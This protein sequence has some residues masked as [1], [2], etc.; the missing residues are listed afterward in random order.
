VNTKKRV[1]FLLLN[2]VGHAAI[3]EVED[4]GQRFFFVKI[5]AVE[6][7]RDKA[8][9]GRLLA[10]EKTNVSQVWEARRRP[11]A[12]HCHCGAPLDDTACECEACAADWQEFLSEARDVRADLYS[13]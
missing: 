3:A 13:F 6:H 11:A 4:E 8:K 2:R 5:T 1:S 12:H 10:I 9:V 7:A